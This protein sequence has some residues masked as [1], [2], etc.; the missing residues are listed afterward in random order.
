MLR[1]ASWRWRGRKVGRRGCRRGWRLVR[2]RREALAHGLTSS[3]ASDAGRPGPLA[4]LVAPGTAGD[5]QGVRAVEED[6]EVGGVTAEGL[7]DHGGHV[8]ACARVVAD[9]GHVA[10]GPGLSGVGRAREVAAER[11][12]VGAPL[13]DRG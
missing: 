12:E 4:G 8:V 13:V 2:L 3:V 10:I 9:V 11:L 6:L 1:R 7:D 5:P